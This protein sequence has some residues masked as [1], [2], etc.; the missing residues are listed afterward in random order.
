[1]QKYRSGT[2]VSWNWG[3]GT[4]EGTVEES[5]TERVERTIKGSTQVRNGTPDN[6]AYVLSQDDGTT[7]LKLH[8]ELET[9]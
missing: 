4:A 6:P 8:S 1:M 5:H 2:T 3:T 9:H 7:V